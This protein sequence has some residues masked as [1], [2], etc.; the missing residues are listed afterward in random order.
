[1]L[2]TTN[3]K[4]INRRIDSKKKDKPTIVHIERLDKIDTE[5]PPYYTKPGAYIS[6][7]DKAYLIEGREI[8][9]W[10]HISI[11]FLMSCWEIEGNKYTK[12]TW[13]DIEKIDLQA[14]KNSLFDVEED[15]PF[16]R[17]PV[18]KQVL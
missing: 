13:V 5:K 6:F 1:M 10:D 9:A 16:D 15:S 7:F 3:A 4:F 17:N 14:P 12:L 2:I 8:I 18:T 11:S